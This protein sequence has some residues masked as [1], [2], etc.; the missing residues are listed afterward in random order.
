MTLTEKSFN[1]NS[2]NIIN[3][4]FSLFPL[5]FILG[6]F[7]LNVNTL[8]LCFVGIFSLKSKI[9]TTR[10]NFYIKI[11]F[12][13]FFIIFFSTSLSFIDLLLYNEYEEIHLAR[14]LKS[15]SFFRF[16]IMLLIIYLL[17]VYNII[18]FKYFF[19]SATFF[20]L[21]VSVDVI[22]QYIFGFNT[23]GLKGNAYFNS[24]FFGDELIAGSFIQR[25]S[26]FAILFAAIFLKNKNNIK[27]ILVTILICSLGSG[28]LLTGNRMPVIL[29]LLGLLLIFFVDVKLK[30]ILL[31]NLLCLSII[32]KFLFSSNETYQLR[33]WSF[34]NNGVTVLVNLLNIPIR[35]IPQGYKTDKSNEEN[36]HNLS[37]KEKRILV[38][39][40]DLFWGKTYIGSGH[41]ILF[42]TALD[43][44]K[45][46]KVF[47]NG[48]RSFRI[49]CW[50]FHVFKEGRLCAN[51]PHNYYLEILTETGIVGLSIILTMG[52]IFIIY[53]FRN[54]KLFK[55]NNVES[56][57][58]LAAIISLI[59][60]MFPLRS[61]GSF[62]S[63]TNATY[64]ILILSIIVSHK[65]F[66]KY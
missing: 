19:I 43:T 32:F 34:Y 13:F 10:L 26:F 62:F 37:N 47:G 65:K 46:N 56:F 21:L 22:F 64:I 11:I 48:I 1:I 45:Q 53:L 50:R 41:S 24:G 17:N 16:F 28:M 29:F 27:F 38:D 33:Y 55:N 4:L 23:I 44:W 6:N 59:L 20:S 8:L 31:I 66:F 58:L 60:E 63:T 42:S 52:L 3:I 2:T 36:K 18:N 39:D 7:A 12:L 9:F 54:F 40:F 51:H 61:S 5:S 15:I 49:D 30:K 57:I 14:L 35:E 25:F